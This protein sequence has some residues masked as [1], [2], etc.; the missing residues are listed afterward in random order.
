M[1]ITNDDVT[2]LAREF[3]L[4]V[5]RYADEDAWAFRSPDGAIRFT[6]TELLRMETISNARRQ[7]AFNLN[8]AK[9]P[10]TTGAPAA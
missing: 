7:I 5:R 3:G 6:C 1:T 8:H 9:R 2:A 4:S 10:A